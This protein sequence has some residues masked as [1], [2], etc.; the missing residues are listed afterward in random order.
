[1]PIRSRPTP[2]TTPEAW[3]QFKADRNS[4]RDAI[5]R[6]ADGQII[7]SQWTPPLSLGPSDGMA[8]AAQMQAYLYDFRLSWHPAKRDPRAGDWYIEG[9]GPAERDWLI[10]EG[11]I[12]GIPS[13]ADYAMDRL[14]QMLLEALTPAGR[15]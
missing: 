3:E 1:M 2:P 7:R 4:L 14:A 6:S 5:M 8:D 9:Q 15:A 12:P 11:P 13:P 10:V